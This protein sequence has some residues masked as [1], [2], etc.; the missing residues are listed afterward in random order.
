MGLT[1]TRGSGT[2]AREQPRRRSRR[3]PPWTQGRAACAPT[4]GSSGDVATDW[5]LW[6]FMAGS[7]R[8]LPHH[9]L[10]DIGADE[11]VCRIGYTAIGRDTD[12]PDVPLYDA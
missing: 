1:A 3:A 10:I 5:E 4:S 9:I 6:I 7:A 2:R 11:H 8:F 12:G